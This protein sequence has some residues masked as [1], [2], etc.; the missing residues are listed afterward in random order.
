MSCDLHTR[1]VLIFLAALPA[2]ASWCQDS[3]E[4]VVVDGQGAPIEQAHCMVGQS[5]VMTDVEGRFRFEDA[6][7]RDG[8]LVKLYVTHIGFNGVETKLIWPSSGVR[9]V[10]EPASQTLLPALVSSSTSTT[11]STSV[12]EV[13]KLEVSALDAVPATSRIQ[14]LRSVAGVHMVSAGQGMIR[15]V[16]RG[17]SGLRVATLFLNSRVESQ[18]WGE[19][20]GI[21]FPEQGVARMDII[22]GPEVLQHGP[23]AYGGVLKVVPVGPLSKPGRL[24]QLSITG[25]GNTNGVQASVMT[26]KRSE[27]AHHVLLT[28][29]NRFNEYRMPDG[30]AVMGSA[31]RQFY[32]QGR[33]GYIQDWGTWEGAYSS[34]YNTAGIIGPGGTEQSG[35]HMLTTGAHFQTG[36]WNWHPTVS[37]QLNHRKE[38]AVVGPDSLTEDNERLFT[39]LDLSLRA[40]R[41]DIKVDRRG[42]SGWAWTLGSQSFTKSNTNDTALID[43]ANQW[44]PDADI[45]GGGGF[46]RV[47]HE[48]G[49]WRPS[50]SIRGDV[51][52]TAWSTRS[53]PNMDVDAILAQGRRSFHMVSGAM[54]LKWFPNDKYILGLS[55]LRG[56]RAP[57]LAELLATGNHFDSFR[58]ERG[59]P[60]L[61]IETSHGVEVQWVKQPESG[62]QWC[63]DVS[64]YASRIQNYMLL[65][66]TNEVNEA[67][68][69]VQL[70]QASTA[71]LKGVDVNAKWMPGGSNRWSVNVSA[72]YVDSR[73][74]RG[75]VL[76]WTPPATGRC[77]IQRSWRGSNLWKGASAMVFEASRDAMLWHAS[78]TLIAGNHWTVRGQWINLTNVRYIP[79][80]SLLQNLG[81]P[82]PGRNLRVQLVYAW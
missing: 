57:G 69:P 51:H 73:D 18:A 71:T 30:E 63:G 70:H 2:L 27:R 14:A 52:Q 40:T 5:V 39:Q 42:E 15:P 66:P 55:I 11:H 50:A 3:L 59:D 60:N 79:T 4:G 49:Q 12:A 31:L 38:L 45:A 21:F 32:S 48:L 25:H 67:G 1:L 46:V 33:F 37:Y 74:A 44:I 16:L 7:F 29:V 13:R 20:H 81:I 56:N 35:D 28:G 53:L 8:Q 64:A 43:L 76:P 58:E 36:L 47:S 19:G 9:V 82:E 80:L 75:E 6:A 61:G 77:E 23:D 68:L 22:R 72:S 17:L 24:T 78:T 26:Q 34:C 54:G 10:M 65:V 41:V 62:R